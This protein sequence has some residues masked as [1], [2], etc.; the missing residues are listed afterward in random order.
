M[1]NGLCGPVAHRS[2]D[3]T[4][5]KSSWGA[6]DQGGAILFWHSPLWVLQTRGGLFHRIFPA[7]EQDLDY[8]KKSPINWWEKDLVP[9]VSPRLGSQEGF[10]QTDSPAP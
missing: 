9:G 8:K 5:L 10:R 7:S 3:H 1:A 2:H 6:D 4:G